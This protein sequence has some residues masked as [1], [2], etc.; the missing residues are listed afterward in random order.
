MADELHSAA[1]HL[2]RRL[3]PV[4]AAAGIGPARLSALSVIIYGRV[5]T[6]SALAA[7]EQVSRPTMSR[8]LKGLESE[9]LIRRR[10]DEDDGRVIR[11]VASARGRRILDEA[12]RRRLERL[13]SWLEGVDAAEV[14]LLLEATECL[15]GL[16]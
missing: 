7:A 10:V 14:D 4:D 8:L 6:L 13:E 11:I 2:L 9:G 3:R 1:I 12:R 15:R 5:D 16:G